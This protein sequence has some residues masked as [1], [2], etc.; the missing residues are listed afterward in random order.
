MMMSDAMEI[1]GPLVSICIPTYNSARYLRESLDS[2]AAQTYRPVEVIIADNA[3]TDDTVVI[4]REYAEKYGF[5]VVES[6]INLG[7]FNNWNRLVSLACGKYVAIYH[8]DDIY[9][10]QI[11]AASVKVLEQDTAVALVGTLANV[12]DEAGNDLFCYELPANIQ[13]LKKG[14]YCY[15]EVLAAILGSGEQRIF[16]VTPSIMIRRDAYL[17]AGLFDGD[18]YR[19]S[20]DYEM[21]LRIARRHSVALIDRPLMRYRVHAHQGSEAER[22]KRLEIPDII[23]VLA[24][25]SAYATSSKVRQQCERFVAR[26]YLAVALKLNRNGQFAESSRTAGMIGG[27]IFRLAARL[28]KVVNG[29]KT[30]FPKVQR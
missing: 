5:R 1:Q 11:V 4:A 9:D 18:K 28:V 12:I 22:Q 17:E 10:E 29:L 2:V 15:D 3:S 24:E 26:R 20:G 6:S 30:R 16:L 14:T 7:P 23:R 27:G 13:Q 19:S 8:S 21:W 25:Y